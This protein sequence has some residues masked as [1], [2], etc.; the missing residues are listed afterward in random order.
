MIAILALA[1][2][3]LGLLGMLKEW[4]VDAMVY[5][6]DLP[7]LT[8]LPM[9][10]L[11]IKMTNKYANSVDERGKKIGVPKN[12]VGIGERD[13]FIFHCIGSVRFQFPPLELSSS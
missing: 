5:G 1:F 13:L 3:F 10:Y 2:L 12:L 11:N 9:A 6:D 4:H 7:L 8:A